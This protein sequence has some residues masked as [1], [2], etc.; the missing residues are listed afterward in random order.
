M[1]NN[2]EEVEVEVEVEVDEDST[3]GGDLANTE[4][5]AEILGIA[6]VTVKNSR[7]TGRLGNGP[8]PE[9]LKIGRSIRYS[10]T[11]LKRK[12]LPSCR[13]VPAEIV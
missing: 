3:G 11:Y 10:K 7:Y 6:P 12:F 4:E 9:Y 13:V 2:F 1:R 5:T 8:A